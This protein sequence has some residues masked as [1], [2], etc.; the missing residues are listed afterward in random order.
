VWQAVL[1]LVLMNPKKSKGSKKVRAARPSGRTASLLSSAV[2]LLA[3]LGV[4]GCLSNA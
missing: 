4:G 3:V 1:S 2:R